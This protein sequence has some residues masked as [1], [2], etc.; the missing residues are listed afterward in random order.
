MGK[1]AG[2][3]IFRQLCIKDVKFGFIKRVHKGRVTPVRDLES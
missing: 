3:G 2:Y 1:A